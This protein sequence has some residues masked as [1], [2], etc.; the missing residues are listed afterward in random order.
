MNPMVVA[1]SSKPIVVLL[2]REVFIPK[3]LLARPWRLILADKLTKLL[4][5]RRLGMAE[6]DWSFKLSWLF[7]TPSWL[8]LW[9]VDVKLAANLNS[10]FWKLSMV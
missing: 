2:E 3:D 6:R 8:F 10:L 1:G 5:L 9:P 7:P 4:F